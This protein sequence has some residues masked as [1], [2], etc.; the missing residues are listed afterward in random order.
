M[1]TIPPDFTATLAAAAQLVGSAAAML[2]PF[3]FQ[4]TADELRRRLAE[5]AAANPH[6][7]LPVEC[8]DAILLL[9]VLD[10]AAA[11]CRETKAVQDHALP[12]TAAISS[13]RT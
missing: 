2:Q 13:R 12:A 4:A 11:F 10:A 9:R 7:R 8:P 3:P 5:D 6:R 1:T